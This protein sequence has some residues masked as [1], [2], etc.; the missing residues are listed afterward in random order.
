MPVSRS[1]RCQWSS[2]G[3]KLLGCRLSWRSYV[4]ATLQSSGVNVS[5]DRNLDPKLVEIDA[6]LREIHERSS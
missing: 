6:K 2:G 4:L 1:L 5:T 3:K